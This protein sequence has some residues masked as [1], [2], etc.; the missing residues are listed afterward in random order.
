VKVLVTGADGFV[1]GYLLRALAEA[2]HEGIAAHRRG[3][4][5]PA[6]AARAVVLELDD[7]E[8]VEAV[9]TEPVDA[10]VHLAAVASGS[11]ARSDPGRAWCVNAGGTARLADAVARR[12][13]SGADPLFLL[14]SSGEVYGA[15]SNVPR[16]ESD[17]VQ[18]GSPY[19]ASKA[20]AE[21]AMA[22]TARRT[23]LR[24]I[25]ARPFPH[26]G[27]GQDP[28]YVVPAFASRLRQAK[29]AGSRSVSTGNLDP[30]RDIA[31]VRDVARAYVALLERG[32]PGETYNVATGSGVRLAE[33]FRRLA[34]IIGVE[35]EPVTD[36]ALARA[37]D[38]PHL[39]GD[40]T[41]LRRDTGWSPTIPLERTLTE[42]VDAQAH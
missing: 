13:S 23:G 3:T 15:G 21:L 27:P 29:S 19:A 33:L 41:R 25:V 35:A 18:P 4:A 11:A 7:M 31:D 26:T 34:A 42:L 30:V 9:A 37:A 6:H 2:G 24:S 12:R 14:V 32:R 5:A 36:P 17:A 40:A 8:S 22:E 16:A 39:V 28:R 20:G 10:V 38:I 1:G